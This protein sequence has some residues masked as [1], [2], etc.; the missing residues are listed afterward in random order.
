MIVDWNTIYTTSGAKVL[1]DRVVLIHGDMREYSHLLPSRSIDLIITDPPYGLNYSSNHRKDKFDQIIG[2]DRIDRDWFWMCD[3]VRDD[4]A[5]YCFHKWT[6]QNN[7]REYI[8]EY[9]NISIRNQLIWIKN[10]D[11]GGDLYRAY[12]E[13]HECIWFATGNDFR[14]A[15]KRP[16]T[17][18]YADKVA[19][20]NLLHPTQKPIQLIRKL[21]SH[22]LVVG[23][24]A[25]VFDPFMG[26]GT[27][28]FV[29]AERGYGFIGFEMD[30]TYFKIACNR[31]GDAV[32]QM[33]L[34]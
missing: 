12:G 25:I 19:G 18:I 6:A 1:S 32:N 7:F 2:D 34:F 24:E 28:G 23:E 17:D 8:D 11:T 30:E 31:I 21:M 5:F 20:S 26:S 22:A 3:T 33:R 4:G 29:A 13:K 10:N 16:T 14:F 27:T 15:S 9:T